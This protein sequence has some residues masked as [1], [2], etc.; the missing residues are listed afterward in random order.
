M[1]EVDLDDGLIW[2]A[3]DAADDDLDGI[4]HREGV[5]AR[6]DGV[7]VGGRGHTERG[8]AR[9]GRSTNL[10]RGGEARR[11]SAASHIIDRRDRARVPRKARLNDR[12]PVRHGDVGWNGPDVLRL[13]RDA[14]DSATTAGVVGGL[15]SSPRGYRRATLVRRVG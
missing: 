5:S 11:A 3:G 15:A 7:G 12:S 2:R 9:D 4:S 14:A 13:L 6:T 10:R 1:G 8:A